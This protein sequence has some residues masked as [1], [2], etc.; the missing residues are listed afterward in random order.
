MKVHP[1]LKNMWVKLSTGEIMYSVD[2]R[3]IIKKHHKP[4]KRKIK[5]MEEDNNVKYIL[6]SGMSYDYFE[7]LVKKAKGK[8]FTQ[9]LSDYKR[10]WKD[11]DGKY[12]YL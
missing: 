7:R 1:N 10:Y 11:K 6:T 12:R 4:T 8:S 3:N 2:K 5:Q 9:L